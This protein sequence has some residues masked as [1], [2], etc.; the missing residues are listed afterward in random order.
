[1][2]Q[3]E[4]QTGGRC[5][6][7]R[8]QQQGLQGRQHAVSCVGGDQGEQ[9]ALLHDRGRFNPNINHHK[10][11]R[12]GERR[13]GDGRV[14]LDNLPVLYS[15]ITI[16]LNE[17][18]W[19]FKVVKIQIHCLSC[20]LETR[21]ASLVRTRLESSSVRSKYFLSTRNKCQ[22]SKTLLLVYWKL[23]IHAMTTSHG[24]CVPLSAGHEY[25]GVKLHILRIGA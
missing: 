19:I 15:S 12:R 7:E 24:A 13:D 10:C 9:E 4:A 16:N 21:E 1:M 3:A 23:F 25:C 2:L 5:A 18:Q 14:V 11:W 6:Q 17:L 20:G 8:E 22:A